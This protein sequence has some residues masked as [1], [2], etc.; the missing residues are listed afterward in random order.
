MANEQAQKASVHVGT[1]IRITPTSDG[2]NYSMEIVEPE[3]KNGKRIDQL[4]AQRILN[5]D[6][7]MRNPNVVTALQQGRQN[8]MGF[9]QGLMQNVMASRFAGG[10]PGGMMPQMGGNGFNPLGGFFGR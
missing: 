3:G 7:Q 4:V 9:L 5:I 2:Q 6:G 10:M 1:T 8:P